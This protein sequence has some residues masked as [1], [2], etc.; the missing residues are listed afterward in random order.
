MGTASALQRCVAVPADDFASDYWGRR[1]LLSS[2]DDLGSTYDDLFSTAAA[3]ELLSVRG[4]RTP[5]IR[6]AKEGSVL[7]PQAFTAPGG[8]GA[9]VGDQV[10]SEKVLAEFAAGSTIVLQ[11][12]HRT[13]PPLQEFT[14]RLVAELGHPAQVNAYITPASSRGFDPHYDVHD[15]FVLQ[16]AGEKRWVIH[17]PVH[18][19][20]FADEPWSDRRDAVAARASGTPAIDTVLRPGDALYLP[21]GYLHS[22][23]ALGGTTIH[24]TIGMP[25]VTRS[26]LARVLVE[27]A[28]R[29]DALRASLPLGVDLAD[30]EQIAAEVRAAAED[31]VAALTTADDQSDA[32]AATVGARFRRSTRPEPVRPLRTVEM[33]AA[34]TGADTVRWRD[35]L[36]TDVRTEGTRVAVVLP[37]GT[38]RLPAVC[39][40]ALHALTDGDVHRVGALPGLDEDDAVVVVRRLLREGVLVPAS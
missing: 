17:E 5:F 12:L 23:T 31:L 25:A 11:G 39:S 18:E 35:G 16:I 24:L 26:D 37:S 36:P 21:R 6:M 30:P 32:V 15:V 22:A 38:V 34:L 1:A 4:L 9:E 2:A 10:S 28:L 29:S 7:S 14:R 3:D 40:E 19:L 20:P 8:Y 13:W 33:A 27:R